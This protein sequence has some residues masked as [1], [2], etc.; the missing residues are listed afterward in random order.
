MIKEERG[1]CGGRYQARVL[2]VLYQ[3][4]EVLYPLLHRYEEK[5]LSGVKT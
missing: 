4:E 1:A 2:W 5:L 3:G